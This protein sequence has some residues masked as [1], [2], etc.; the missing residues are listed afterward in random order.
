MFIKRVVT[1][2]LFL[3]VATGSGFS[4]EA[5]AQKEKTGAP[6]QLVLEN[7]DLS[8]PLLSLAAVSKAAPA[9]A[10]AGGETPSVN[11][12]GLPVPILNVEGIRYGGFTGGGLDTYP[13]PV[14][15]AGPTQYVQAAKQTLAVSGKYTGFPSCTSTPALS[16]RDSVDRARRASTTVTISSSTI[17]WPRASTIQCVRGP[18][19]FAT[20]GTCDRLR[21]L[22]RCRCGNRNS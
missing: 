22:R 14:I 5:R 12:S 2:T 13:N 3:L 10:V 15:A 4:L 1:S 9:T 18:P 6:V 7:H 19:R 16:G 17:G 20:L 11:A 8:P 21:S